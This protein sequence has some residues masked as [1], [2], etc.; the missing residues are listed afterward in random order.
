M[1]RSIEALRATAIESSLVMALG[2][3]E[4]ERRHRSCRQPATC[5]GESTLKLIIK[6]LVRETV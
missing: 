3:A 4:R 6:D 2:A 1:I 5:V